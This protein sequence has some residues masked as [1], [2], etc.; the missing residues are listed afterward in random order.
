M[1]LIVITGLA[2]EAR[3]AVTTDVGMIVGAGRAKRLEADLEAAIARGAR[4]LLSFGVAGALDPR[5]RAGDLVVAHSVRDGQ[6][7]LSCD[8]AWRTAITRRLQRSSLRP[9]RGESSTPTLRSDPTAPSSFGLFRFD[10]KSGWWPIAETG[11]A[12]IAGVDLP[13]ADVA[14]KASLFAS[15]GAA[16]VDMESAIVARAA[17]RHGL[18]FAILRVIADPALRPLPSS[19]LVAMRADG[20]VD[21]AAVLNTLIRRPREL[22]ALVRLAFDS[23]G[24][25]AAL[26]R[27]RELLGADFASLDLRKLPA[28]SGLSMRKISRSASR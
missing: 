9:L 8:S 24:A 23:R 27:V 25:F 15:A 13:L 6:S 11:G 1:S 21:L 18:P 26:V 5:L 16:A 10:R 28:A 7:R 17:R 2:A 12:D 14:G 3:I 19:A 4:R 22:P 20:E